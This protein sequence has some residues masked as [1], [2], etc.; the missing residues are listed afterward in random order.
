MRV[1]EDTEGLRVRRGTCPLCPRSSPARSSSFS[2]DFSLKLPQRKHRVC[3]QPSLHSPSTVLTC[4]ISPASLLHTCNIQTLSARLTHLFTSSLQRRQSKMAEEVQPKVTKKKSSTPQKRSGL[5]LW[6]CVIA[7]VKLS[8]SRK[9][10]SS[11]A[12]KKHLKKDGVDVEKNNSRINTTIKRLVTKGDLIQ[13]TGVGASGSYKI[14]KKEQAP[15]KPKVSR[16]TKVKKTNLKKKPSAKKTETKKTRVKKTGV[17][18]T[19]AKKT[20]P[21][22]TGPKKP[23]VKKAGAKKTGTK[24]TAAK[25]TSVKK[26]TTKKTTKTT[27][28]K[29]RKSVPTKKTQTKRPGVRRGTPKKAQK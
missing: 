21:K 5:Q 20:G 13:V 19:G 8:Q 7:A 2:D 15:K 22:K 14:P 18:K 3:R 17:K 10:T 25:K 9:G 4:F 27:T 26:T 29:T 6:K 23:R 1:R 28:K 24:K 12:I 16:T 11:V